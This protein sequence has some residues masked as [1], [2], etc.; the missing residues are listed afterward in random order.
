MVVIVT[1]RFQVNNP[2]PS[3][4]TNDAS[5]LS[6]DLTL[7]RGKHQISVGGNLAYWQFSFQSHARS[8][9]NWMFTA[10]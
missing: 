3:R 1:G 2:G 4:F 10:S 9:G 5:Q 8:G 7:V 6:N